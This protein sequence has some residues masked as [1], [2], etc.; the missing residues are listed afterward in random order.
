MSDL[1][2]LDLARPLA[3]AGAE[4]AL[5][6]YEPFHERDTHV[7]A[8]HVVTPRGGVLRP[9]AEATGRT[10]GEAERRL[11]TLLREMAA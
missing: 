5:L 2:L 9:L 11:A 10:A 6:N 8:V 1:E 4:L 3:P 7:A